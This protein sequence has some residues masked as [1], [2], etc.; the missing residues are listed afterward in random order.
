[1]KP[2]FLRFLN[3]NKTEIRRHLKKKAEK[4]KRH[5][6]TIQYNCSSWACSSRRQPSARSF[7]ILHP[8]SFPSTNLRQSLVVPK[9][10]TRNLKYITYIAKTLSPAC[11]F[12]TRT[13][14]EAERGRKKETKNKWN[15]RNKL[16]NIK[17]RRKENF[18]IDDSQ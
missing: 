10:K 3:N 5:E 7:L 15:G 13:A 18:K 6:N 8:Q 12:S 14:G 11:V 16:T 2:F 9:T 17:Q 4:I 1:M